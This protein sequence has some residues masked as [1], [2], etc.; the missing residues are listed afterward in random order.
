MPLTNIQSDWTFSAFS[1]PYNNYII[2]YCITHILYFAAWGVIYLYCLSWMT[3]L[4]RKA[5]FKRVPQD[6]WLNI[7]SEGCERKP[8]CFVHIAVSLLEMCLQKIRSVVVYDGKKPQ[9]ISPWG[10]HIGDFHSSIIR[11]HFVCPLCIKNNR[12]MY[13]WLGHFVLRRSCQLKFL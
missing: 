2:L 13:T 6:W 3:Q 10:G 4:M 12:Q 1:G 8:L 7:P 9:P 11:N 5:N